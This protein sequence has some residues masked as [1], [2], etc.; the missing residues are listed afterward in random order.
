MPRWNERWP[1][2]GGWT[3]KASLGPVV[4]RRTLPRLAAALLAVLLVACSALTPMGGPDTVLI[5]NDAHSPLTVEVSPSGE[6]L[7]VAACSTVALSL[8]EA[9]WRIAINGRHAFS[10]EQ[11]VA[12]G[13]DRSDRWVRIDVTSNDLVADVRVG[14]VPEPGIIAACA[15]V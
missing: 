14:D 6:R 8:D 4:I 1:S 9:G 3:R 15:D 12:S 11:V 2:T 7:E 5:R 10:H 13:I